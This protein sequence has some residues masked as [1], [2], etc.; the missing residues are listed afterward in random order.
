[1]KL[2]LAILLLLAML[3]SACQSAP[4]VSPSSSTTSSPPI[5]T[6]PGSSTSP[7]A[8]ATLPA[9]VPGSLADLQ[10]YKHFSATLTVQAI[11]SMGGSQTPAFATLFAVP[12]VPI[13]WSGA[14]F[15]G[16][17]EEKGAGEDITDLVTGNVSADGRT[18]DSLVYSR[19]I[20]R[21]SL[22]TG[23]MFRITLAGVPLATVVNGAVSGL[24]T[25]SQTGPAVKGL[26]TGVEYADG[27]LDSTGQ[28]KST[29]NLDSI[30]WNPAQPGQ[31]PSIKL[32]FTP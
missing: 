23:N 6:P 27:P 5:S 30:D 21:P 13:S 12:P 3:L 11:F 32:N 29:T 8:T 22:S 24:G 7:T 26:V 2:F 16:H 9:G 25:F 14:A 1:V 19:Q 28:I 20:I 10:L 18:L 31:A 15:S 4:P 17:L